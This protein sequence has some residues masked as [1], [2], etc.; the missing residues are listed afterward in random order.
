TIN[1]VNVLLV[2]G[3]HQVTKRYFV[4]AIWDP[5]DGVGSIKIDGISSN[6]ADI[7]LFVTAIRSA[8]LR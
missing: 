2:G 8:A 7:A 4:G 5:H 6:E 3:W 1:G